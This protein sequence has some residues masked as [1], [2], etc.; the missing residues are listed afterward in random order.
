MAG[1]LDFVHSNLP[2]MQAR[3]RTAKTVPEMSFS[4]SG[5]DTNIQKVLGWAGLTPCVSGH[6]W[7]KSS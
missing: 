7:T 2:R 3:A 6:K 1:K 5:L 4:T